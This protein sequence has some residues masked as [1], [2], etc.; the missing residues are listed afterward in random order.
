MSFITKNWKVVAILILILSLGFISNQLKKERQERKRIA[1]NFETYQ[2]E[3]NDILRL[4]KK[5]FEI[6]IE[7]DKTLLRLLRDSL[8]IKE[9]RI[10]SLSKS[11][12]NTVVRYQTKLKDT[13]IY[14]R[15]TIL[16]SQYF[17]Y[18]DT[19]TIATGIIHENDSVDFYYRSYDTLIV[20]NTKYKDG[21]WFLS[22]W[23]KPW[24]Y[25]TEVSNTN[26]NTEFT[27]DKS[28]LLVE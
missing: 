19:W 10:Q 23:F 4:T 21:K 16:V 6:E 26:P 13:T 18:N 12:N 20:V 25:K 11:T 9:S 28:I 3:S 1:T 14:V 15:D 7:N 2:T 17:S 24:K 22:K 27:L 5:E 8:D